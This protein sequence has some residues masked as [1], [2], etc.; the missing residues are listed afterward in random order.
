M[1]LTWLKP[2]SSWQQGWYCIHYT[3]QSQIFNTASNSSTWEGKKHYR[4]PIC[5]RHYAK[6]FLQISYLIFTATVQGWCYY[7]PFLQLRKL[8]KTEVKWLAQTEAKFEIRSPH[9]EI[10][11]W[12]TLRETFII[13]PAGKFT[14]LIALLQSFAFTVKTT[15]NR[16]SQDN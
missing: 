16:L 11:F 13:I 2:R 7:Y 9:S 6:H 4:V 1:L 14:L 10:L 8:R 3:M 12:F 15:I 5:A